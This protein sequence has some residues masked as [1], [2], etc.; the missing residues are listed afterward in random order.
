MRTRARTARQVHDRHDGHDSRN[1]HMGPWAM[2]RAWVHGP[3][4]HGPKVPMSPLARGPW[5]TCLFRALC[6]FQTV[7]VMP[8]CRHNA[9]HVRSMPRHPSKA[10]SMSAES[11]ADARVEDAQMKVMPRL[12]EGSTNPRMEYQRALD[13][14]H[15]D[16]V[17]IPRL[18]DSFTQQRTG[19]C[20]GR[21][22]GTGRSKRASML[23]L[24][25]G[26]PMSKRGNNLPH[27]ASVDTSEAWNQILVG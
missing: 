11:D 3:L 7:V 16:G 10:P 24:E 8:C 6:P 4:A 18:F 1:G 19:C 9:Q 13:D 2:G 23:N 25:C 26:Y 15:N 22:Q 5:R 12:P 20:Q 17:R 21:Q 27:P 14:D